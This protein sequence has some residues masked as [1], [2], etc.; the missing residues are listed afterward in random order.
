MKN[1]TDI[2]IVLDRSSSMAGVK[3]ATITGFNTFLKDQQKNDKPARLSLVQFAGPVERITS[4]SG[5]NLQHAEELTP[6]TYR[7]TGQ[8]TALNDAIATTVDEIGVRLSALSE[9][10]RPDNVLVVIMTDGGENDSRIY[11]HYAGV[12]AKIEHQQSKYNWQ[13]SFIGANQDSFATARTYS[14]PILN[15]MN[16]MADNKGT[17]EAF[18]AMSVG[19][20]NVRSGFAYAGQ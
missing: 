15:T 20:S 6:S 1:M 10:E 11:K 17:E 14:I 18:R 4:F 19:C 8:S 7:P 3:E 13:F 16:Y 9:D 5:V 12:R 2:T